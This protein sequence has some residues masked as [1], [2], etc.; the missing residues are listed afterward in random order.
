MILVFRFFYNSPP[1]KN[2]FLKLTPYH[3]IDDAYIALD[4]LHYLGAYVLVHI[5]RHRDS[6]LTILTKL[7]SGIHCLKETL[8]IDASNDEDCLV[9]GFRTL[10]GGADANGREWMANAG[11]E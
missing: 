4:D 9:D 2:Y 8:L 3:L 5:V 11:E 7:D 10:G 1:L 6:M